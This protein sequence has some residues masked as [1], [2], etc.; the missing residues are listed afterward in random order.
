ML[1][2]AKQYPKTLIPHNMPPIVPR[3]PTCRQN[4]HL[5][6]PFIGNS[7]NIPI[8]RLNRRALLRL[9]PHS[10]S[11]QQTLRVDQAHL[12]RTHCLNDCRLLVSFV[13]MC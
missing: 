11:L 10:T 3:R 13:L 6:L 7:L 12:E 1:T 4:I 5:L 9:Y 8:I 2:I